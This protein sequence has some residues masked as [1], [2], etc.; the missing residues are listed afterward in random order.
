[1]DTSP[2][3]RDQMKSAAATVSAMLR[4]AGCA[5]LDQRTPCFDWDLREL[6]RHAV[7][8][9]TG[10]AKIGRKEALGSDPWAAPEFAPQE[11]HTVLADNIEA[12]AEAWSADAA[13]SGSVELGAR[14]PAAAIGDMAYA[15]ILLHGWDV[16]RAVGAEVPVTP[17][18]AA[19]LHRTISETAEMGRQLGVYGAE[20]AVPDDA[21]D[22]DRALGAAGRNPHWSAA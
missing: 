2:S 11:W 7:G 19:A 13:W 18:I 8:T 4:G 15:E 22:F 10:L 5:D 21:T 12:V 1:M 6:T 3:T 14:M 9:T 16:A 17:E 20:V